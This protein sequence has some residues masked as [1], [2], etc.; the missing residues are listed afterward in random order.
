MKRISILILF[1]IVLLFSCNSPKKENIIGIWLSN[2][3]SQFQFNNDSTFTVT[4]MPE[5]ILF[6]HYSSRKVF[7]GSGIWNIQYFE[8]TWKIELI[9]PKSDNLPSGFACYLNIEKKFHFSGSTWS[10]FFYDENFDY[11]YRFNL[12]DEHRL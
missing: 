10:L 7:S 1:S 2:N 3:S 9:F 12:L 6:G 4:D 8:N 5:S 11:K